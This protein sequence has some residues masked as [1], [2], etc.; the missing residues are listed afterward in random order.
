MWGQGLLL[1]SVSR[2]WSL[3]LLGRHPSRL[4]HN[5]L[6]LSGGSRRGRKEERCRME[7]PKKAGWE[8]AWKRMPSPPWAEN[9]RK[10]F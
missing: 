6:H 8:G 9:H 3:T 4:H 1:G 7:V 10:L 2:F 5:H